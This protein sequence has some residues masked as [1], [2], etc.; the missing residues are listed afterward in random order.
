MS[1]SPLT[2]RVCWVLGVIRNIAT[3]CSPLQSDVLRDNDK[4]LRVEKFD[5]GGCNMGLHL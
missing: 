3:R 2:L 1:S 4:E 5:I